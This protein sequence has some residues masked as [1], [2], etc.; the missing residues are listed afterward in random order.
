MLSK[1]IVL[2][3]GLFSLSTVSIA[4]EPEDSSNFDPHKMMNEN[5]SKQDMNHRLGIDSKRENFNNIAEIPNDGGKNNNTTPNNND[6]MQGKWLTMRV[7]YTM[8]TEADEDTE[9]YCADGKRTTI[10]ENS[11]WDRD[12]PYCG[13]YK[14]W[15]K[16]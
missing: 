16:K 9:V 5:F 1:K 4:Q 13:T 2:L 6:V 15:V 3:F 8:K 7:P 10:R 11:N 14:I 12:Y